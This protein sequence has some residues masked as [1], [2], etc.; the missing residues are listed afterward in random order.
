MALWR[1]LVLIQVGV[2]LLLLIQPVI[3]LVSQEDTRLGGVSASRILP[4]GNISTPYALKASFQIFGREM[5]T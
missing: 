1:V 2:A 3:L 4:F 5:R